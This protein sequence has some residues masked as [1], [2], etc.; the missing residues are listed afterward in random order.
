MC[1][2]NHMKK[3]IIV[4]S[5]HSVKK[6]V[7]LVVNHLDW[8][9]FP[10]VGGQFTNRWAIYKLANFAPA[11]STSLFSNC[12]T[13]CSLLR[14]MLIDEKSCELS[15]KWQLREKMQICMKPP[16]RAPLHASECQPWPP[17]RTWRCMIHLDTWYFNHAACQLIT[18]PKM[19][20]PVWYVIVIRFLLY[21]FV[22]ENRNQLNG[23]T[24]R[25]W[26]IVWVIGLGGDSLNLH[27]VSLDH[28]QIL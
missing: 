20:F 19:A 15:L 1:H 7:T 16:W 27:L 25:E 13:K 26:H 11:L 28:A 18:S 3:W 8:M 2:L 22:A 5:M 21:F 6:I 10:L 17:L 12:W 4:F 24:M 23:D 14:L 9:H